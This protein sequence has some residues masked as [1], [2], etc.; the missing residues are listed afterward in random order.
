MGYSGDIMHDMALKELKRH[1]PTSEG[2]SIAG[3]STKF[4]ENEIF[5]LY[6]RGLR[7]QSA[8]V[9]IVFDRQLTHE[10][11]AALTGNKASSIRGLIIPQGVD[12][13]HLPAGVKI[14]FMR[15]FR[16]EGNDLL[17]LKKPVTNTVT[18]AVSK[19]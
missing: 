19:A 11:I 18:A 10:F 13:S 15:A 17:W 8:I 9:G 7:K 6:R 12:T 5:S 16:Y 14:G 1:Y 3:E 2:W 4:G